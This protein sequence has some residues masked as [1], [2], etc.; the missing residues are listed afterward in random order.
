ML[1]GS[2]AQPRWSRSTPILQAV[3]AATKIF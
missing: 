1:S 3:T 2:A